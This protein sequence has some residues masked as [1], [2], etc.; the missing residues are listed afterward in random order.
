MYDELLRQRLYRIFRIGDEDYI[1]TVKVFYIYE[2]IHKEAGDEVFI[3]ITERLKD[4]KHREKIKRLNSLYQQLQEANLSHLAAPE[5]AHP[6]G[7]NGNYIP[8]WKIG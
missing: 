7:N 6:P 2:N 5:T 3:A 1:T 4:F 8:G